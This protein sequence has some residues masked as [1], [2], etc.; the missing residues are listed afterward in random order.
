MTKEWKDGLPPVG[1]EVEFDS[2]GHGWRKCIVK[3]IGDKRLIYQQVGVNDEECLYISQMQFRPIKSKQ[4]IKREEVVEEMIALSREYVD[5]NCDSD[6][7]SMSKGEGEMF[8]D[9]GYERLGEEVD[10]FD[11]YRAFTPFRDLDFGVMIEEVHKR[12]KI[13]PRGIPND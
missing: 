13:Y 9:A 3:A 2:G 5:K 8:I 10:V 4:E 12:F 11:F 1:C 7:Y 6:S